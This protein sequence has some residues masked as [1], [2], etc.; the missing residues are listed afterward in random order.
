MANGNYVSASIP[1]PY[2]SILKGKPY[3]IVSAKGISNGLSNIPNDGADFGPDTLL[4]ASSPNQYGPPYTQTSGIQEAINTSKPVRLLEG[5]FVIYTEINNGSQT[6]FNVV[7]SGL[8]QMASV[9]SYGPPTAG[10]RIHQMTAGAN[11]VRLASPVDWFIFG[12]MSLYWDSSIAGTNTGHGL[13]F[14]AETYAHS[15]PG[16]PNLSQ[17]VMAQMI[18]LYPLYI[19]GAD[20]NHYAYWF[21]NCFFYSFVP[22]LL[23]ESSGGLFRFRSFRVSTDTGVD[24]CN[25]GNVVIGWISGWAGISSNVPSISFDTLNENTS[26]SYPQTNMIR[27]L[28]LDIEA[29]PGTMKSDF[30]Y[31]DA[32]TRTVRIDNWNGADF[33][34]T[35]LVNRLGDFWISPDSSGFG[36]DVTFNNQTAGSGYESHATNLV[37][38]GPAN[39]T[40]YSTNGVLG[41]QSAGGGSNTTV[42]VYSNLAISDM[43]N[44]YT[45]QTTLTGT[46]AGTAIWSQPHGGTNSSIK[47]VIIYLNG[48]EN[49]TTTAQTISFPY[50]FTYTPIITSQPSSFSATVTTTTLTLPTSM[51]APVTGWVI[52]EGF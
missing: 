13:F 41:L 19:Y 12:D 37:L 23:A 50:P 22:V 48:Y 10:T 21:E 8:G 17:Y 30:I 24:G 44:I 34:A 46:T 29:G 31:A 18:T 2:W 11:I 36:P 49:T 6:T 27:I 28:Y 39:A 43:L 9:N 1:V 32:Y 35:A 4:G 3:V 5:D 33:S 16:N 25:M 47:K 52:I 51:T 42:L 20:T 26:Y 14:D 40:I 45:P 38:N 7:G 15:L